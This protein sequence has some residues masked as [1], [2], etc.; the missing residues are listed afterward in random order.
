MFLL[1]LVLAYALVPLAAARSPYVSWDGVHDGPSLL[2]LVM[3]TDYGGLFSPARHVSSDHGWLRVVEWGHVLAASVG[4]TVVCGALLG[5]VDRLRKDAVVGTG[6]LLA[7]LVPGPVFAWINA[8]DTNSS[9]TLAY[10]ER[11]TTMSHVGVALLFGAGVGAARRAVEGW[12]GARV[13]QAAALA[14]WALVRFTLTRDVDLSE[15][16]G[17]IAFAHDVILRTPD[18]SLVLLSGDQPIDAELYVCGVE[19]LCGERVAFAPGMLF[20]PWKMDEL[21]RRHPDIDIPWTEGAALHRT[22]TLVDAV[23]DRPVY[24]WPNLLEKDPLLA[25]RE[26]TPDGL[27]LRV[28]PPRQDLAGVDQGGLRSM[29]R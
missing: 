16:R 6:L 22:H 20:L 23:H 3:R 2:R 25:S 28:G 12:R 26:M 27:L 19:H 1:P 10:F 17:G 18:R 24:L 5:V 21:R 9:A 15:E 14:A 4:L 29:S 8:L 13:T 11:F 7:V